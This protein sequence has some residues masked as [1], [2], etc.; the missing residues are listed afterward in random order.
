VQAIGGGASTNCPGR[1]GTVFELV[2]SSGTY[3]EK[4]LYSFTNSGGDGSTPY[5][6]LI[7]DSLGNLYGTTAYAAS[8]T[9]YG[10]AFK[11]T[12]PSSPGLSTNNTFTG[13]NTFSQPISGSITGNAGTVTNGVYTT[14]SY[15]NPSW[16]TSLDGSKITGTVANAA[17][18]L[19]ALTAGMAATAGALAGNPP[20]NAEQTASPQALH[21]LATPIA[22]SR[23][24]PT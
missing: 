9:L 1:C 6:G 8:G 10:T 12:P 11:L 5:A 7:M 18:A 23:R 4:V 19:N 20:S 16:I 15:D 17:N 22:C 21:P 24:A 3:S 14:G 13:S 2:N